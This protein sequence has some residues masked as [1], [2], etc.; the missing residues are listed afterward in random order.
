MFDYSFGHWEY[1]KHKTG[2]FFKGK[3]WQFCSTS[4]KGT[5]HGN[6]GSERKCIKWILQQLK[7]LVRI[8]GDNLRN[9]TSSDLKLLPCI[10]CFQKANT[11]SWRHTKKDK[12][13][14]D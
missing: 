6:V 8:T 1:N 2:H 7:S 13:E 4:T 9:L 14:Q 3:H 12:G 10:P 5:K 11:L